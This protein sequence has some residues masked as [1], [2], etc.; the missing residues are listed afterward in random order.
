VT[1]RSSETPDRP[2]PPHTV[3]HIPI[4]VSRQTAF[5][6]L[7]VPFL[8]NADGLFYKQDHNM[9]GTLLQVLE[10]K[11]NIYY[12]LRTHIFRYD[13]PFKAHQLQ[14]CTQGSVSI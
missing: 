5:V 3:Q 2:R 11:T 1:I 6:L 14:I 13:S 10:S 9:V 7:A 8:L 4:S 12:R